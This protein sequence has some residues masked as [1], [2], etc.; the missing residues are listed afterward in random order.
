MSAT[1]N[2]EVKYTNTNP[3]LLCVD[4][5]MHLILLI[6]SE[7]K[8]TVLREKSAFLKLLSTARVFH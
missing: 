2:E 7:M 6:Y 8:S 3:F 4:E 5:K 1:M